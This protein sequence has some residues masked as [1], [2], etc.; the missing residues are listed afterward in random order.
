MLLMGRKTV[1]VTARF[2]G[3]AGVT[4]SCL[5][6]WKLKIRLI[7]PL[8]PRQ[9]PFFKMAKMTPIQP[10]AAV[11]LTLAV[12]AP[13]AWATFVGTMECSNGVSVSGD[14][15]GYRWDARP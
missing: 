9:Q 1:T 7:P 8:P 12:L 11:L 14:T 4:L 6:L 10:R 15:R 2:G 3:R 5:H 13:G